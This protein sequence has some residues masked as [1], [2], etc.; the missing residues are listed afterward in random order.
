V[1]A[2]SVP[3][4]ATEPLAKVSYQVGYVLRI[5]RGVRNLGLGG[6][7]AADPFSADNVYY[8]PANAFLIPG[9]HFTTNHNDY[10]AD[11]DHSD[12]NL[13]AGYR[14]SLNDT[15]GLRFGGGVR[16][17]EQTFG[18]SIERTIF[19]P[20]GTGQSVSGR[21][22][23]YAIVIGCGL[24]VG[25]FDFGA[26]FSVKPVTQELGNAKEKYEAYDIGVLVQRTFEFDSGGR[27]IPSLGFS[28][29]NEGNPIVYGGHEAELPEQ[30][31]AGAGIRFESQSSQSAADRL[32]VNRPIVSVSALLEYVE[33]RYLEDREG[34]A[35][36]LESSVLDI[37]FLR[38]FHSDNTLE[39]D[40]GG[41][42]FGIGWQFR[43]VRLRYDYA[44]V[45]LKGI[46]G[47][48]HIS[49]HGGTIIV[50]F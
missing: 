49:A 4:R 45:P 32:G 2:G 34:T 7:G 39:T 28:L 21:D 26:G 43:M 48:D 50:D 44:R 10:Y 1:S 18:A 41:Y 35:L 27:L 6:I 33:R 22:Y 11:A 13:Y 9:V 46:F 3:S 17:T 5:P 16:Y 25:G 42:G 14:L 40:G 19:L 29:L 37:L 15:W 8:N 20:E 30:F 47:D 36:G 38:V 23:Y 31:R 12:Y 24:N